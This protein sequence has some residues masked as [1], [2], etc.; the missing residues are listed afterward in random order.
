MGGDNDRVFNE[1][2]QE[3]QQQF[4]WYKEKS[5]ERLQK[6]EDLLTLAAQQ[7]EIIQRK[8]A[9]KVKFE[10]SFADRNIPAR[11]TLDLLPHL[12]LQLPKFKEGT[13]V[14][15]WLH[16]CEQYFTIYNIEDSLK[17][18][19]AGMHL[20]GTSRNWFQGYAAE[21][22]S[23]EW[24]GFCQQITKR[25]GALFN[26]E[27]W[28]DMDTEASITIEEEEA[29]FDEVPGGEREDWQCEELL[30]KALGLEDVF[31]A[32]QNSE[33]NST[34][35]KVLEC[36]STFKSDDKEDLEVPTQLE[37][38]MS[39][40]L[41]TFIQM[42]ELRLQQPIPCSHSDKKSCK[43][44]REEGLIFDPGG[45]MKGSW[46]KSVMNLVMN[47]Q[48][49]SH[50]DCL[51][52]LTNV[53]FL[54]NISNKVMEN[55]EPRFANFNSL[56][57]QDV[58]EEKPL[59]ILINMG[60]LIDKASWRDNPTAAK[61]SEL[62]E[63]SSHLHKN[64]MIIFDPGGH[65]H[66]ITIVNGIQ[67][68]G[69]ASNEVVYE[70]NHH[71]V[72]SIRVGMKVKPKC[73]VMRQGIIEMYRLMGLE[74]SS[75][76]KLNSK[77]DTSTGAKGL[78]CP[79]D[80]KKPF[81]SVPI[82]ML[83]FVPKMMPAE[84]MEESELRITPTQVVFALKEGLDKPKELKPKLH[85]SENWTIQL[86]G[87][88]YGDTYLNLVSQDAVS[89]EVSGK[90]VE[91]TQKHFFVG[92]LV[93]YKATYVFDPG[94]LLSCFFEVHLVGGPTGFLNFQPG[95]QDVLHG[96]ELYKNKSRQEEADM[97]LIQMEQSLEVQD[98]P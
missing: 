71:Y 12:K 51:P 4:W 81:A 30:C 21:S 50:Q 39:T 64:K 45:S 53:K 57:E 97:Y 92:I 94:G 82:A 16:D 3:V 23:W 93:H 59:T 66:H 77:E 95:L 62:E 84:I 20:E 14:G 85:V 61:F 7:V 13:E 88:L 10:N 72:D 78:D 25:F 65:V 79:T 28:S 40:D 22:V 52:R 26:E 48:H 89:M 91:S 8:R 70:I 74:D 75:R 1:L 83:A 58:V 37:S 36:T 17:V 68:V 55:G 86:Q 73:K 41:T 44:S 34:N 49:D 87:R 2:F 9:K 47:Q 35:A 76:Y 15:D 69:E 38:Q 43:Y 11:Q 80:V 54:V 42:E 60:L 19:V 98:P 5:N 33:G 56:E 27:A 67:G 31:K 18:V 96:K 46:S 24:I 63:K 6:L 90:A 29:V 32:K